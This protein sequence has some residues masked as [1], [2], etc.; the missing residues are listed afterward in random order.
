MFR[1]VSAAILIGGRSQRMGR[2]KATL[3]VGGHR[4]IDVTLK[5]LAPH[6]REVQLIGRHPTL[7]GLPD[8]LGPPCTL[9]GIHT[10]LAHAKTDRVFVTA[11]DMPWISVPLIRRLARR[12]GAIVVPVTRDGPQPLHA[13]YARACLARIARRIR[14]GRLTVGEML[15]ALGAVLVPVADR[16]PFVNV[17]T[18]GEL[19]AVRRGRAANP[20]SLSR[21]SAK[22]RATLGRTRA[23]PRTR[24]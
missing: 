14:A 19:W 12:S 24:R 15:E 9:V 13:V 3:R 18:P 10:A 21:R 22:L 8:L 2:D 20:L 6:F 17:N 5:R 1:S 11:C 7:P 16:R 23:H 4:L